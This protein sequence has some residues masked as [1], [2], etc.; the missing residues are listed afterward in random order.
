MTFFTVVSA[1]RIQP[2]ISRTSDLKLV[3]G[4]SMALRKA[5]ARAAMKGNRTAQD[6]GLILSEQAPDIDGVVVFE[7]ISAPHDQTVRSLMRELSTALPGVEWQAWVK[8]AETYPAARLGFDQAAAGDGHVQTW[9]HL[10][11]A[12]HVPLLAPCQGCYQETAVRERDVNGMMRL[13]PDCLI[14]HEESLREGEATGRSRSAWDFGD[15]AKDGGVS[16]THGFVEVLDTMGRRGA[17]NHLCTIAADGNRIGDFFKQVAN[18]DLSVDQQAELSEAVGD[19]TAKALVRAAEPWSEGVLPHIVHYAGGDDILVSVAAR[20]AWEFAC[21]LGWAFEEVFQTRV[22]DLLNG[23]HPVIAEA[24]KETSLAIG[25]AFTHQKHPFSDGRRL[26]EMAEQQAKR[27]V[28]GQQGCIVWVDATVEDSPPSDRF[29][30]ISEAHA[31]L[32]RHPLGELNPAARARLASILRLPAD[33]SAAMTDLPEVEILQAVKLWASR[34][35]KGALLESYLDGMAGLR[36]LDQDLDRARWWP[37]HVMK[38][39]T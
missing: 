31:Q 15:L 29:I 36:Q 37:A 23:D 1:I 34:A 25:M 26:A 20:C 39:D 32:A 22:K 4:S 16:T 24:A 9:R 21:E 27:A 30:T 10:P 3:R 11:S 35:E 38:G 18:S 7:S 8:E 33:E 28:S 17:D 13:G 2:W 14:R 6:A 5:T 12:F 19:A